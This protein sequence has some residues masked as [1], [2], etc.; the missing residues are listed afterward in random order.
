MGW[1]FLPIGTIIKAML[2]L[3]HR[4]RRTTARG[5]LALMS[6]LWLL[7]AAAPCVMAAPH[8]PGMD[9]QPCESMDHAAKAPDCDSL[10]AVDC[11]REDTALNSRDSVPDLSMVPVLL[12][13]T[14]LTVELATL[15]SLT[16]D[17][18]RLTLQLSPPP[19]YI[20]H[21]VLLI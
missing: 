18:D 11:Q 6:S 16:A 21:A 14:P 20:Q 9:G 2:G 1:E 15:P 4:T 19:L 8:C 7:A 13:T 3:T 5:L 17:P 10:Q 12:A